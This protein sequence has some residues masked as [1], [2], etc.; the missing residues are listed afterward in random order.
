[1]LPSTV[2]GISDSPDFNRAHPVPNEVNVDGA[3]Y[4]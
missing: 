3:E 2:N 4:T 1:M